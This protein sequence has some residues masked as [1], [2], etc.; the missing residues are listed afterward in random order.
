VLKIPA[1]EF[2]LAVPAT[3]RSHRR[4]MSKREPLEEAPWLAGWHSA[5][6]LIRPGLVLQ[7]AALG[8]VL[9]YYYLPAAQGLFDRLATWRTAG[10]YWFSAA[11]TALCGGVLP[12]LYLRANPAT[13]AANPWPHLVVF[14]LFWAWKGAETDLWYRVL[15]VLYGDDNRVG[16]IVGKV[17]TDQFIW[18]A[19][20]AAPF[21]SLFFAWKDAG[22]R[23]APV[24]ADVRAG[25]WYY[26]RV[27][28]V[29]LGVWAVWIPVVTCVYALPAPLQMPLFNVVLCFWSLLFATIT[30]RQNR[31]R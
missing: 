11:S 6:A 27:L 8:L 10:G 5:Q 29:L 21:S 17:L 22:F 2:I 31:G 16:T 19:C 30:A 12:F 14:A 23:P 20:Y 26:R 28:P 24:A 9:A 3:G 1:F 4:L 25:R 15:A 18:N 13:R 7:A